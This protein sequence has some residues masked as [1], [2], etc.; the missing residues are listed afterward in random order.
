MNSTIIDWPVQHLSGEEM[1]QLFLEMNPDHVET[2]IDQRNFIHYLNTILIDSSFKNTI[3]M[4][5][6]YH[7][8]HEFHYEILHPDL[9]IDANV[10]MKDIE[11][12]IE[13]ENRSEWYIH[14]YLYYSSIISITHSL[15]L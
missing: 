6:V 3:I 5:E 7:P 14:Q 13:N 4:K 8:K 11:E 12:M 1:Q 9:N 10:S 2:F 15:Y